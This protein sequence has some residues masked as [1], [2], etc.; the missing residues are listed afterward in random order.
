MSRPCFSCSTAS[1]SEGGFGCNRSVPF[2]VLLLGMAIAISWAPPRLWAQTPTVST[3]Q[4]T[5]TSGGSAVTSVSS[6]SVVSLAA[7]VAAGGGPVTTGQVNFCDATA[8]DCLGL[9]QLAVV[10]LNG[11]G[12]AV[13]RFRPGSGS[14]RFKAVFVGTN[15][16]AGSA[17]SQSSLTVTAPTATVLATTTTMSRTGSW[18]EYTLGAT[19]SEIGSTVAPAGTISFVDTNNGNAVLG[20]GALGAGTPGTG[21]LNS[22]LTLTGIAPEGIA[23]GDFNED[24]IPDIAS[25][26]TNESTTNEVA[27][28]LGRGDGT[29]TG[30]T[31]TPPTGR[32][33]AW[34]L[35]GDFNQDGHQD[36][37]VQNA[38]DETVT[39]FLGKGDGTFTAGST[40]A[41]NDAI[42]PIVAGDFN[43]DG[44]TDLVSAGE[45]GTNLTIY[46]GNG[47]GTFTLGST[48]EF[49]VFPTVLLA[50]DFNGDGKTDL[51]VGTQTEG[52]SVLLGNGNGTFTTATGLTIPGYA[53][54]LLAGDFNGDGKLDL[55]VGNDNQTQGA[56]APISIFLGNGDGTFN[57]VPN[58]TSV[59]SPLSLATA[60]L[61]Q[62]GIPDL[63]T[64]NFVS[65]GVSVLLGHGDGTFSVSPVMALADIDPAA[66][67]VAD[68]NGDGIPDLATVN[69][70]PTISINIT[71]PTVTTSTPTVTILP[72]A[73]GSHLV[74]ASYPG[75]TLYQLSA[76]ATDLL[77]GQPPATGTAL[78][79]TA[80]GVAVSTTPANTVVTLTA[81][82]T[83]GGGPVASGQVN[84]CDATALSC[85][86][87]HLIGSAQL[88]SAGTAVYRFVP[89]SG[90]HQY[91]AVF[92][93]SA[94]GV[95]SS[96]PTATLV[97][98]APA[99]VPVPT[100]TTI[101]QS[102][103]VANYT[104]T[105]TVASVGGTQPMT[106]NVSFEDTS[107]SNGVLTTAQ[108]GAGT[109][110]IAWVPT[111]TVTQTNPGGLQFAGGD[112]NGDGHADVAMVD[113]STMTVGIYLGNG[114]GTYETGTALT[115]MTNTT[116]VVAGDFN[117]D[118]ILDL[119]VSSVGPIY[120]YTG[121]LA[122]YLGHGDGTFTLSSS[123]PTVGTSADVFAT[124]DI[125]GDGKLDLIINEATGTRILFGNGD[126]TFSQGPANGLPATAAVADLN[127]D[128]I[129]DIVVGN[130][131]AYGAVYLGNGDGTFHPA[132]AMP[133]SIDEPVVAVGDFN[134]DGIPD[135]TM[136]SPFGL[137]FTILLGK[138]DGSFTQAGDTS[139]FT[140]G[141]ARSIVAGDFNHDG[142]VDILISG[143]SG[144]TLLLGNG[145]GTFT[146]GPVDTQFTTAGALLA[147][148]V[149]GDGTP[150]IVFDTG[151]MSVLLTEPSQTSIATVTGVALTGPG[152]HLVDAVYAGDTNYVTSTSATTMLF[153]QA[154]AP[155][156]SLAAGTYTSVQTVTIADATP[157]A[158]IY[159]SLYGPTGG[160]GSFVP[161]TGP[162]ALS[163]SGT[164]SLQAYATATGYQLSTTS[165]AT[166][167]LN[168]PSVP[169][170][171]LSPA[172]GAYSSAQ[173]VTITETLPGATM[174]YTV[175]GQYPTT[176]SSVYSGPIPV[177]A[178]ETIVVLATAPGYSN[179]VL[180]GQYVITA[181][182][183]IT[184]P[185]PS[186]ISYGTA[187]G[188]AQLD[189]TTSIPGT[190][191]YSPAAGTVLTAGSH[192]LTATFTPTNTQL[193]PVATLTV[194]LMVNPA[195]PKITWATP[196]TITY[197]V[198][199][200]SAQLDASA[201]VPGTF[202]YSP[203]VGT[204]LPVGNQT[205]SVTFTPTDAS[206]YS[207]ATASVVLPVVNPAPMLSALSP[208]YAAAGGSA[209]SLSVNGAGFVPSSIVIWGSTPLATQYVSATQLTASIPASAIATAGTAAVT[210]QTGAPGGGSSGGLQFEVDSASS[211]GAGSPSFPT[212]TATVSS[213]SSAS[214]SVTLPSSAVSASVSCLNLPTGASCSYANGAV[215]IATTASTPPGTYI[216]TMVFTETLQGVAAGFFCLPFLLVPLASKRRRSRGIQRMVF[217]LAALTLIAGGLVFTGC[218]GAGGGSGGGSTTHQ[219]TSSATVT[220]IVQ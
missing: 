109:A 75:S 22:T 142:K 31:F 87:I 150:D 140:I 93:E 197:G 161:Y 129:P 50:A 149:N 146:A 102:G 91:K 170:P 97:V 13:Y 81:T 18:G 73:P 118:G 206:D 141:I 135:L 205:L 131:D 1:F 145:D 90:S 23:A 165:P 64:S 125:N 116:G 106:G 80:G 42:T 137:G 6:G 193:Y 132:A 108:L 134:G 172:P 89:G 96:S 211:Q 162:V 29:F 167:T 153:A 5:V 213:G 154:A 186:A 196:S 171:M 9:H 136:A 184:W 78:A 104:L 216:I 217:A 4:L 62:D 158:T 120:L 187:L 163:V 32:A 61:N 155:T 204:V 176:N 179:L 11:S 159:Y 59:P 68:F 177:T 99:F 70:N 26:A 199:L 17:S 110:S 127:G 166:Y 175:N 27:I 39:I 148:D 67:A 85:T 212:V 7:S 210:V 15:S 121:Y 46:F 94:V 200:S 123:A 168:L 65:S 101:A 152:T 79:V 178:T 105:A 69:G 181:G 25:S 209:F 53:S 203:A 86:D 66:T 19:V 189:A 51:I 76:S 45:N 72:G 111:F 219:A 60:D 47:D 191:T 207:T 174:Y 202:V 188:S 30:P 24:G 208:A 100:T 88:T 58:S 147:Q 126:G 54:S 185:P 57:A 160:N 43:G 198:A 180:A 83:A 33:P 182:P 157:G 139:N 2:L 48:T 112:F 74:D 194:T 144:L 41:I 52:V 56:T 20:N 36:L 164:Y 82:V 173:S 124:A 195:A 28:F 44:K 34:V 8:S 169:A 151:N 71:E 201:S 40:F 119:A 16:V 103:P 218:G 190:F 95:T 156:F 122:I 14:R 35:V 3:T 215:T 10:Q 214:Y 12:V 92:L 143:G 220:L 84:F 37:A 183:A 115:L 21:W 130:E 55:A 63:I 138:G 49:P 114:D 128:G 98:Q 38:A 113:P 192:T 77:W 133:V 117:G 107:N